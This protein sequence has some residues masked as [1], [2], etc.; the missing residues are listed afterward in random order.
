MGRNSCYG[1]LA[2]R[3]KTGGW[4]VLR[5]SGDGSKLARKQVGGARAKKGFVGEELARRGLSEAVG[6]ALRLG[7]GRLARAERE[8]VRCGFRGEQ[9]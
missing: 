8:A 4:L 5:A 7:A 3:A 6:G 9:I 1:G 2:A